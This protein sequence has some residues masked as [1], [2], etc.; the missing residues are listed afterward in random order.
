MGCY[1]VVVFRLIVFFFPN[2][3][4]KSIIKKGG[5][6]LLL[7]DRFNAFVVGLN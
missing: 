5:K 3:K 1:L 6:T 2:D 7:N 4:S